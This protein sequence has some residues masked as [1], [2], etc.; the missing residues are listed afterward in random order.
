M[1]S[2]LALDAVLAC[3]SRS[4]ETALPQ[5]VA[6]RRAWAPGERAA[7]IQRIVANR[8]YVF[9]YVGDVSDLAPE[10][11]A[12]TDSVTVLVSDPAVS[13]SVTG[14]MLAPGAT[15]FSASWNFIAFKVTT[16]DNTATPP[17]TIF[18]HMAV[19]ADPSNGG[20]HGFAIAF[21]RNGTFNISQINS[22]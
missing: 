9:P 1:V 21:S 13:P 10:I 22:T 3:S 11:Y 6:V 8:E 16:V 17:D 19:W 4:T 20:N 7:L 14:P 12:D 2:L 18:W 5:Y 15:Q